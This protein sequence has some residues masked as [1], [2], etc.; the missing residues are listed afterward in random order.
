MST[1]LVALA[2]P[3]AFLGAMAGH[4]VA[5]RTAREQERWRKREETMRILRW[6]AELTTKDASSYDIGIATL[7]ALVASPLLDQDDVDLVVAVSRV[8]ARE[9]T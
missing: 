9:D 2:G 4:W 8:A 6:A 1:L 3:L 5:R 7:D